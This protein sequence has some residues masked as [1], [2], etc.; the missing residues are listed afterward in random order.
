MW[1]CSELNIDSISAITEKKIQMK[2]TK[3]IKIFMS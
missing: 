1:H 2:V 3:P